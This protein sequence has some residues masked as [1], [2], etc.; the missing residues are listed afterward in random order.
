MITLDEAKHHLRID[1]DADDPW[2]SLYIKAIEQAILLWLG[3]SWRAYLPMLDNNGSPVIDSNG[4]P[5]AL[6]DSDGE[7]L[8][9][10]VVK[11]AALVEL[12]NQYRFREGDDG[13]N[14]MPT[15]QGYVLGRGATDLLIPL[16]RPRVL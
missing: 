15:A 1:T 9:Q 13:S 12:A 14:R 11:I 4:D 8:V 2:L 7:P 3:E 5:V 6:C 16:R 10:P